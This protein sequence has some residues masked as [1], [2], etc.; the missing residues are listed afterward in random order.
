MKTPIISDQTHQGATWKRSLT[1]CDENDLPLDLAGY[2]GQL[3]FKNAEDGTTQAT[4]VVTVT[5]GQIED[6]IEVSL[7]DTET[8]AITSDMVDG[9]L[10]LSGPSETMV[11]RFH[12]D[13]VKAI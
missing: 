13:I 5:S 12:L 3:V 8:A 2:S 1:I 4:A 7:L 9:D 11:F 10:F 6:H